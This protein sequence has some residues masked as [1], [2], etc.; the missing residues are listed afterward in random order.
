[1]NRPQ[2]LA[3]KLTTKEKFY[4]QAHLAGKILRF[5]ARVP[6]ELKHPSDVDQQVKR[7]R[8]GLLVIVVGGP[9]LLL[10]TPFLVALLLAP[11][12]SSYRSSQF[13]ISYYLADDTLS[14]F[15][16]SPL[17]SGLTSGHYLN[18]GYHINNA[19][20]KPF[21]AEDFFIGARLQFRSKTLEV[22]DVDEYSLAYTHLTI[23]EIMA[24]VR[25]KIEEKNVN[26]RQ[27][28]MD[29]DEDGDFEMTYDEF[30]NALVGRNLNLEEL[31]TTRDKL[32]LFRH[33]D[34]N[35]NGTVTLQEF[36]ETIEEDPFHAKQED[37]T[38]LDP[39]EHF[40]TQDMSESQVG[41]GAMSEASRLERVSWSE[42]AGAKRQQK[43]HTAY[44]HN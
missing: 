1:L 42:S 36:I 27:A 29:M 15:C 24:L 44:S 28:F 19:S 23:N 13:V 39:Y 18:R 41:Q 9:V 5:S 25:R 10:L 37:N 22:D 21:T 12:R 8:E 43:Q 14:V 4:K 7:T 16:R 11:I 30:T 20:G 3:P 38:G 6:Q 32:T 34:K 2:D 33:F 17:N 26:L 35:G 31:L 40:E